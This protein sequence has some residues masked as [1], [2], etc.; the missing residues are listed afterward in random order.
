MKKIKF[1]VLILGITFLGGCGVGSSKNVK[2][3]GDDIQYVKDKRT[4]LCFA[5]VGS[6]R[7]TSLKTTGLGMACVPCDSIP[8]NLLD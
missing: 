6:S 5:Y 2:I 7:A 3:N 4:N 8:E 1:I